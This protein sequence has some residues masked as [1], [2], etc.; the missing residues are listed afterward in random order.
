MPKRKIVFLLEE[1]D[2]VLINDEEEVEVSNRTISDN[3]TRLIEF[4]EKDWV[5]APSEESKSH[6]RIL[7]ND[8]E[9]KLEVKD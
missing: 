7:K 4:K 6:G 3:G 9:V 1:G 2:K 5:V 8:K